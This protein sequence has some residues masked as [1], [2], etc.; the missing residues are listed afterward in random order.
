[1]R[2]QLFLVLLCACVTCPAFGQA[3]YQLD[4][5]ATWSAATHGT[6]YPASAH[7]SPLIGI[8]HGHSVSFWESGGIASPGIEHMAETGSTSILRSEIVAATGRNNFLSTG[9]L[10]SPT[11][12]SFEFDIAASESLI[13]LVTMVAPSPDWFV[14]VSGLDL[15]PGGS[16]LASHVADLFVYDAGTD[17][18]PDFRSQNADIT[19][20]QPIARLANHPVSHAGGGSGAP[21]ALGTFTFT[22]LMVPEPST[23]L[24]LLI[25]CN[26]ALLLRSSRR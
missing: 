9:T 4:F 7:F 13:T 20:H 21:L 6:G 16:W 10:F 12:T 25:G 8:T 5:A 17:S 18:G 2:L 14:G 15:R 24:L 22:L 23:V 19:P 26:T 3:T 1:M 11:A